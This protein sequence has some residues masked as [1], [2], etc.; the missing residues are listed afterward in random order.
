MKKM[1]ISFIIICPIV[2]LTLVY[3][4]LKHFGLWPSQLTSPSILLNPGESP[5][6]ECFR[7]Q[8]VFTEALKKYN[9]KK[10]VKMTT[11][12]EN[13][14]R[15]N[16]FLPQQHSISFSAHPCFYSIS[17][18][19][20]VYCTYHGERNPLGKH[21]PSPKYYEYLQRQKKLCREIFFKQ[22][23]TALLI[24]SGITLVLICLPLLF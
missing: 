8:S 12:N 18:D 1:L 10:S 13:A 6:Y 20:T 23:G 4:D 14:L 19:E 2:F 21:K 17:E 11:F 5:K 15:E 16:G 3:M 22:Y 24:S 9:S 7:E